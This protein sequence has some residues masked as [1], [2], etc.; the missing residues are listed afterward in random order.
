M[1]GRSRVRRLGHG[2]RAVLRAALGPD[3]AHLRGCRAAA[4]APPLE[5]GL[6]AELEEPAPLLR[7]RRRSSGL[8]L[9]RLPCARLH[10]DA[11]AGSRPDDPG[12]GPR[13]LSHLGGACRSRDGRA[14]LPA[15]S[16]H[17]P[18]VGQRRR[19]QR[20]HRPAAPGRPLCGRRSRAKPAL[21]RSPGRPRRTRLAVARRRLCRL[22]VL[23]ADAIAVQAR[24][25]GLRAREGA[26]ARR[27]GVRRRAALEAAATPLERRAAER[28]GAPRA[29]LGRSGVRA[30]EYRAPLADLVLRRAVGREPGA[31]PVPQGGPP[32]RARARPHHLSGGGL[33]AGP[34]AAAGVRREDGRDAGPPPG[35]PAGE[36]P[37]SPAGASKPRHGSRE[38]CARPGRSTR[39]HQHLLERVRLR[40]V[41]PLQNPVLGGHVDTQG[42]PALAHRAPARSRHERDLRLQG[43]EAAARLRCDRRRGRP[44][45]AH[46]LARSRGRRSAGRGRDPARVGQRPALELA[47]ACT[48][49]GEREGDAL[50]ARRAH[51]RGDGRDDGRRMDRLRGRLLPRLACAGRRTRGRHRRSESRV[52][53]G[54]AA[55]RRARRTP[56]VR[57]GR[58]PPCEPLPR[59]VRR[60]VRCGAARRLC[61][62]GVPEGS[63]T[64][65][66]VVQ[67][68]ERP[69]HGLSSRSGRTGQRG[70]RRHTSRARGPQR[71]PALDHGRGSGGSVR[72]LSR[73]GESGRLRLLRGARPAVRRRRHR[74]RRTPGL[75]PLQRDVLRAF[76]ARRLRHQSRAPAGA[77][78][79][80]CASPGRADRMGAETRVDRRPVRA[81]G[82]RTAGAAAGARHQRR[83]LAAPGAAQRRVPVGCA[84]GANPP[85]PRGDG[86]RRVA[87]RGRVHEAH[88]AACSSPRPSASWV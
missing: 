70:L 82:A 33:P 65:Y 63:T 50:L 17:P 18:P 58:Q 64:A 5:A 62:C 55:D 56:L 66:N 80:R 53:G 81:L 49:R 52:Q 67:G 19:Q 88:A 15:R 79:P 83:S 42:R 30:L 31:D 28:R 16:A 37:W 68:C 23:P 76:D 74:E 51:R 39:R 87:G 26:R 54:L 12:G 57:G 3:A 8:Q 9:A 35:L 41:R 24:R 27:G 25:S 45:S 43:A 46:G 29:R 71:P 38:T 77:R 86:G 61:C 48:R 6:R 2:E 7:I 85:A 75:H 34:Q 84:G 59:G 1:A 78:G 4:P 14:E 72:R 20:V 10:R 36:I 22:R 60:R 40:P 73:L 11:R 44:R 13:H 69:G 21:R 32:R 47:R